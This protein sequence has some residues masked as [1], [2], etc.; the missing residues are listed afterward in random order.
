MNSARKKR[1]IF[2][3]AMENFADFNL[4]MLSNVIAETETG[5][6]AGVVYRSFADAFTKLSEIS[7]TVGLE[8]SLCS[9]YI[10]NLMTLGIVK[11][12]TPVTEPNSKRPIYELADFFFRFPS[13]TVPVNLNNL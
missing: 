13:R 8:S 2:Y 7:G 9:K 4:E 5:S 12:E 3:A 10:S 11:R 6:K 1:T